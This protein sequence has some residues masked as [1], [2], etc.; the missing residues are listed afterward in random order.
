M[1]HCS[2][3]LPVGLAY[4][5]TYSQGGAVEVKVMEWFLS[6]R[7]LGSSKDG[8]C[9]VTVRLRLRVGLDWRREW[10]QLQPH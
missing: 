3:S 1:S 4:N 8:V 2:I 6:G 9:R 10:T 5:W 7:L